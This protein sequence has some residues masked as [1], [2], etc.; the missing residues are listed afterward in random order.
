MEQNLMEL[1][2]RV[3]ADRQVAA[4]RAKRLGAKGVPYYMMNLSHPAVRALY[5]EWKAS[6][7]AR[8]GTGAP[9]LPPDMMGGRGLRRED[10]PGDIERT[11]FELELLG[12][13]ARRAIRERL[14]RVEQTLAGARNGGGTDGGDDLGTVCKAAS[15]VQTGAG[16]A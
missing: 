4:A 2:R 6:R 12:P 7:S 14:D 13:E 15:G 3:W 8:K 16:G 11:C 5:D 1:A 10:A 9:T